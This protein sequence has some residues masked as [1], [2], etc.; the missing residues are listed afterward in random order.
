MKKVRFVLS[1][2]MLVIAFIVSIVAVNFTFTGR[3]TLSAA[4]IAEAKAYIE[5][6]RHDQTL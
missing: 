1:A 2:I 4:E 5:S 6:L 3:S